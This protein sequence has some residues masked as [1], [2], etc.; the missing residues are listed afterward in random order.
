MDIEKFLRHI[1]YITKET[2]E[3][4]KLIGPY[5]SYWSSPSYLSLYLSPKLTE[6]KYALVCVCVCFQ[7]GEFSSVTSTGEGF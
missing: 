1:E 2:V 6:V 7:R 3:V 5:V 4:A